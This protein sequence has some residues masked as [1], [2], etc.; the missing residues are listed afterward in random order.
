MPD[1]DGYEFCHRIKAN[2]KICHI[3][4]IFISVLDEPVDKVRAFQAGGVDYITKPFNIQELIARVDNQVRIR[5]L[6][7][8]L[9]EQNEQLQ[10][11]NQALAQFGNSL[12]QLHR[13]S[14]T[15][16]HNFSDL[17]MDYI[18]TGCKLLGFSSG[19][20]A[21]I[22]DQTCSLLAVKSEFDFLVPGLNFDLSEIYSSKVIETQK[23]VC[24]SHISEME[25]MRD[26]K[27]YQDLKIES[28]IG[29]PI[30]VDGQLYGILAFFSVDSRPEKFNSY[31]KE[32]IE[33][34]AKS[35]GKFISADQKDIKR[36][37]V[38]EKLR[39]SEERW[40]LA[41]Q[42]SQDGIFDLN[43]QTYQVFYSTRWKEILGY[44]EDE[45][46][47][48]IDEWFSRIHPDDLGWVIAANSLYTHQETSCFIQEYRLLCRDGSYKWIL[49]HGQ[50][51]WDENGNPV[52]FIGSHRD[53]SDR[54]LQAEEIRQTQLFLDSIIEN[55]PDMIFVKDAEYLNF[56]RLNKA[57]E[58]LLGYNRQDLIGKNDYNLFAPVEADFFTAK[59]R[60]VL[61]KKIFLDIPEESVNTKDKGRRILHTKKIPIFDKT[62]VPQYLLGISEDI[63][64]Q[65]LQQTAL[66]LIVEGTASKT[67]SEFFYFLVRYLAEV[68][69]IRYASVARIIEGTKTKVRT[70]ACWRGDDFG[71]NF[72][73][74]LTATVDEQLLSGEIVYYA[75]GVK[76]FFP[77]DQYL[78]DL[79]VEGYLGI[80]LTDSTGKSLGHINVLNNQPI[81]KNQTTEMILKIFADR[82]GAEL[83]R[84][85]FEDT[86]QEN[87]KQ[88]GAILEVVERM[89]QT[90]DITKIF[91]TTTEDLRKLFLCDRVIIYR[92]YPD[93]S[94]EFV[95]ESVGE[96]WQSILGEQYC[97]SL[98]QQNI[99]E[100]T[101]KNL[102]QQNSPQDN[103]PKKTICLLWNQPGFI[104]DNIYEQG[105]SDCYIKQL[106][107]YSI[108]AY[109]IVPIYRA[110]K[111]WGLLGVYQNSEPRHWKPNDINVVIQISHNLGIALYQ[112]E[113]FTQTQQQS[114]ELVQAKDAAELANRAKS[115]FL[116][117]MSHELRTPLNAILGFTQLMS[118]DLSLNQKHQAHLNIINRSGQHLLELINDV[119]DMSKI[120][121]GRIKLNITDFDF[122]ILL[123]NLQE[124]LEIKTSAK[125]LKLIF[126]RAADIPQYVRTD[127]VKLRQI[128]LNLLGNAIKFTQQGHVILR[129]RVGKN[130]NQA[131]NPHSLMLMF[132]VED[133]GPGITPLGI[134]SL[135]NPFVQTKILQNYEGTGLGLAISQNFVRLMGGEITVE[136]ILHQGSIFKFSV[137]VELAKTRVVAY[138]SLNRHVIRLDD[139]QANYRLLIVENQWESQQL[140]IE[141]LAPLGFEI[142]TA[143]DGRQAIAFWE[144]YQPHLILMDMQMPVMNGYEAT[145]CIRHVEAQNMLS[146][147]PSK[148]IALTASAFEEQR[149]FILSIGCDDFIRKPFR[150][151]LLLN[152]LAEHLGIRYI[153]A[154]TAENPTK[155]A[156][157][158]RYLDALSLK[159]MPDDWIA[160]LHHAASKCSQRQ[161]LALIAQIP[162][163]HSDIAE[164]ITDLVNEFRFETIVQLSRT[165]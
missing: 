118:R 106:E 71:E 152:K 74:N 136:S 15:N 147:S 62:G 54:K 18:T 141:L 41:I 9:V 148:I 133:T 126:D 4:V 69:Q 20:V 8:Q 101:F 84:Q 88:Q 49:E 111:L 79:D 153:Y 59:D 159:F 102:Y 23:T 55:I 50:T 158:P 12:K 35:I 139:N 95:S 52:R 68:L 77:D 27:I 105:F 64:V 116:A 145:Q 29:T 38:E 24:F 63:T 123:E 100:C 53:I 121:A 110:D 66:Q 76:K 60:E 143:V 112:A 117:N 134:K 120:E 161:T 47:D 99:Q 40:Q 91:R 16:F 13:M 165:K 131:E 21:E 10:Q 72:E 113:L 81:M 32:F 151:E 154:Q 78:Q 87:V 57:G 14:M 58:E 75:Q 119:L 124:L 11:K 149:A 31:A 90:L 98:L 26:C 164:T 67:G 46:S 160:Q 103:L 17:F 96:N 140:L 80:P 83:E 93:W 7:H 51:I 61:A 56:I 114:L 128:L 39:K 33:L 44:Q 25:D 132:D 3:P 2:E 73:Y 42:A 86:L 43:L 28:Y 107:R 150:E 22:K 130:H 122:Y 82:A 48:N 108:Y 94:G 104:A 45:I 138:R 85:L 30:W 34:M 127:E 36:Q 137:Q 144:R 97:D 1:I 162:T 146:D 5:D 89:R 155:I 19:S 163:T 142:Y 125:H 115:E 6:Q 37:E 156:E 65:K 92:F 70:L 157:N 129:V 135:F 109:I